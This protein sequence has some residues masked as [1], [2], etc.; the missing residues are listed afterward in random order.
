MQL[1]V[2]RCNNEM[3]QL[4]T[5]HPKNWS[6]SAISTS[7]DDW[8]NDPLRG[9]YGRMFVQGAT[10]FIQD[11]SSGQ[12]RVE[13]PLTSVQRVYVATSADTEDEGKIFIIHTRA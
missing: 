4:S 3:F 7:N 8:N 6:V 12:I 10:I 2:F 5:A 13:W 11:V 1:F 9:V